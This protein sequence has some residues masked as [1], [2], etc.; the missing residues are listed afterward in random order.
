MDDIS[1]LKQ[2]IEDEEVRISTRVSKL[3]YEELEHFFGRKDIFEFVNKL[4]KLYYKI[5]HKTI[6][7][8][9]VNFVIEILQLYEEF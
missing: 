4:G 5:N 1:V 6:T 7:E 3:L 9:D 8:N 2:L